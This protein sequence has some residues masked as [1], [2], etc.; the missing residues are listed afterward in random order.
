MVC[1][2]G[3][4]MNVVKFNTPAKHRAMRRTGE[5]RRRR[6]FVEAAISTIGAR[7][8]AGASLAEIAGRAGLSSG[9]IAHY[10][11]DRA[12]LLEAT[13]RYLGSALRA[14]IDRKSVV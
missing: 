12:G 13:L 2:R 9:L 11:D 1:A 7:G 8:L 3:I 5:A 4:A 14:D 10:F 6:Q